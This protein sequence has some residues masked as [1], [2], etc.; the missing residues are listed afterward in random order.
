MK[1]KLVYLGLLLVAVLAG[2]ASWQIAQSRIVAG[3]LGMEFRFLGCAGEWPAGLPIE[4]I[5]KKEI[6]AGKP[7]FLVRDPVDCGL[8]VKDPRYTLTGNSLALSYATY[9]QGPVA[10]CYCDY[11]SRFTFDA[12]PSSVTKVSFSHKNP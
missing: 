4:P 12:V 10:A 2:Y 11:R 5:V 7:S 9:V 1:R 8:G 6:F 3:P